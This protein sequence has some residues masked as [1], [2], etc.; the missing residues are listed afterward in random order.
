MHRNLEITHI[1]DRNNYVRK[2]T[3]I[4]RAVQGVIVKCV[5]YFRNS[6]TLQFIVGVMSL[7]YCALVVLFLVPKGSTVY[8]KSFHL[9][10]GFCPFITE[11]MTIKFLRKR[12]KLHDE[13]SEK[14]AKHWEDT[15]P[16][17][18]EVI[19]PFWQEKVKK[20][21]IRKTKSPSRFPPNRP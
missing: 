13:H 2:L 19:N 7:L 10:T 1:M 4:E 8:M 9:L 15:T 17:P 16:E 3:K 5:V 12:N 21:P 20:T 18:I 14:L 6:V 11:L